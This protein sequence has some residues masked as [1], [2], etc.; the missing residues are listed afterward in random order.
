MDAVVLTLLIRTVHTFRMVTC[1][2]CGHAFHPKAC[3]PC[4]PEPPVGTWMK[5]R[6]G[7][8]TQRRVYQGHDGWGQPGVWNFG[9]WESMWAARGP[10]V[11]CGPWG[12]DLV[13]TTPESKEA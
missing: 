5:D 1:P 10:Y 11:E 8:T 7:G 9:V 13:P 4:P 6:F 2:N 12:A 3:A